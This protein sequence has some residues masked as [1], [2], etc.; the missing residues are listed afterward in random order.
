MSLDLHLVR[1]KPQILDVPL[2]WIDPPG[3]SAMS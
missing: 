2:V 1:T 3:S